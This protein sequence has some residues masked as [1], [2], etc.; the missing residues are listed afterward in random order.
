MTEKDLRKALLGLDAAAIAS[1]PDAPQITRQ[2]LKRDRR[3]V[4]LLAALTISLWVTAAFGIVLV[5]GA[6]LVVHPAMLRTIR[7]GATATERERFE[8]VRLM[9]IEKTTAVVAISVAILALAALGTVFVVFAAHAA[10]IRRVNATLV[11]ISEQLKQSR[12]T[13]PP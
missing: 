1:V 13:D 11:A 2:V 4:R 3:R 9:M 7:G 6:L 10:T 5:L 8:H 12:Q